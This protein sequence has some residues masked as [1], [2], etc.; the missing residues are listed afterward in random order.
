MADG[1][2]K[3]WPA[4]QDS[5]QWTDGSGQDWRAP[6]P[7][8]KG[9]VGGSGMLTVDWGRIGPVHIQMVQRRCAG[10]ARGGMGRALVV[11]PEMVSR[12]AQNTAA[13][14]DATGRGGQS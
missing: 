9:Q 5:T 6:V 11:A 3:T 10:T 14:R 13:M 1:Q 8:T 4:G 7:S 12:T 2:H